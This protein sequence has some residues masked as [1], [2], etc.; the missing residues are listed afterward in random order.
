MTNTKH[1]ESD[2]S[3]LWYIYIVMVEN[4]PTLA[5]HMAFKIQ[6]LQQYFE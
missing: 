3:E 5:N 1:Q 4:C 2:M 6:G